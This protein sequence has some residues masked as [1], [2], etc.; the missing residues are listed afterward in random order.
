MESLDDVHVLLCIHAM[1]GVI[2]RI[3]RSQGAGHIVRQQTV[4]R[5]TKWMTRLAER[6]ETFI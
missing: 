6:G 4:G 5:V 2:L 1:C 3:E